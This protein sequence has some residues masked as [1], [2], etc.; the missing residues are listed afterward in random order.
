MGFK[1]VMDY[2][3]KELGQQRTGG[4][5]G[6]ILVEGQFYSPSMPEDLINASIDYLN[7]EKND[8][9]R[10]ERRKK[11]QVKLKQSKDREGFML[12]LRA[13]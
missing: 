5:L 7:R 2:G 6:F 11:Y 13:V 3:K 1:L 12:V 8:P 4:Y 10:I 9:K